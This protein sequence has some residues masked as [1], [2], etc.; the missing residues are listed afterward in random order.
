MTGAKMPP[1][2]SSATVGDPSAKTSTAPTSHTNSSGATAF[3]EKNPLRISS[4]PLY[5]ITLALAQNVP[6]NARDYY[7]QELD[8]QRA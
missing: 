2:V 6:E 1:A 5:W 7:V 3:V 4:S 8:K